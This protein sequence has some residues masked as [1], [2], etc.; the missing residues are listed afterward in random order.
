MTPQPGAPASD[1][2][3]V[4]DALVSTSRVLVAL[5]ARSLGQLDVEI[6]LPQ[7]RMLVVLASHGPQRTVDL[8]VELGVQSSTVTRTG[9]RLVR[10]GM[11]RR[12]QRAGGDRRVA[13]IVLTE[14]GKELVGEVMRRRRSEL[15][16]LTGTID[17]PQ[18]AAVAA[19]LTAL[20]E[21]AGEVPDPQWWDR[22]A[23]CTDFDDSDVR[24]GAD[25]V[26]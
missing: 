5:T 14:P 6:T 23:V 15:A 21:A 16:R 20:V 18:P 12:A 9:D 13:W 19:A 26:T 25:S 17:I 3:N 1:L 11:V 2:T 22:W 4:V 8:A 7:F 24:A 10:K